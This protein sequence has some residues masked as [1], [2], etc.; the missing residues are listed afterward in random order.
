M[1][2][3]GIFPPWECHAGDGEG[4]GGTDSEVDVRLSLKMHGT[5]PFLTSLREK[6]SMRFLLWPHIWPLHVFTC[7]IILQNIKLGTTTALWI[8]TCSWKAAAWQKVVLRLIKN[9]Y[10]LAVLLSRD[11]KLRHVSYIRSL[12]FL[13]FRLGREVK[14]GDWRWQ[15]FKLA[16]EGLKPP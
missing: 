6:W 2:L 14:M 5:L 13:W 12:R 9:N 4:S 16:I 7:Q 11:A 15:S 1:L 3:S 8:A 10:L